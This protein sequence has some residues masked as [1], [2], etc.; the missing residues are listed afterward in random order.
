M[1]SG[2]APLQPQRS[3]SSLRARSHRPPRQVLW[4][5]RRSLVRLATRPSAGVAARPQSV[6]ET[7]ACQR[8]GRS[9]SHRPSSRPS[10]RP[11]P[12]PLRFPL[13]LSCPRT[14]G[15]AGWVPCSGAELLHFCLRVVPPRAPHTAG[16][17]RNLCCHSSGAGSPRSRRWQ[18]R[19]PAGGSREDL[20]MPLSLA[21]RG[22]WHSLACGP[23]TLAPA[24]PVPWLPSLRVSVSVSLLF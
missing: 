6:G 3:S 5:P 10:A 23:I 4:G 13:E 2:P 18:G 16:L 14:R 7:E 11:P 12:G 21:A 15:W 19:A 22:P 8:L 24:C 20:P 9:H 1:G 17:K